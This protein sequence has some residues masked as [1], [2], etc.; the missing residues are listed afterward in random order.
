MISNLFLLFDWRETGLSAAVKV[1][2]CFHGRQ[3]L[4]VFSSTF[5]G[6]EWVLKLDRVYQSKKSSHSCTLI[7][8]MSIS[9]K[10]LNKVSGGVTVG[11]NLWTQLRAIALKFQVIDFGS[12]KWCTLKYLLDCFAG[13]FVKV[14]CEFLRIMQ[15]NIQRKEFKLADTQSRGDTQ[16]QLS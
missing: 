3:I 13:K 6:F 1:R 16:L 11:K 9:F 8:F 14:R 10:I 7:S 2:L 4:I 12:N 15:R 5:D